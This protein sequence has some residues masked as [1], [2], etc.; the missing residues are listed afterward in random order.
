MNRQ[1]RG[2]M[3]CT[4]QLDNTLSED[5]VDWIPRT[6]YGRMLL[7]LRKKA[8]AEGISL[9]TEEEVL[10]EVRNRRSGGKSNGYKKGTGGSNA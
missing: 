9:L 10:E 4:N 3:S 2:A 6:P 5:G 1:E 8:A 7:S